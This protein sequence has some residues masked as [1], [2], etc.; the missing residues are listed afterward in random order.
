MEYKITQFGNGI[1]CALL[2][3]LIAWRLA[4][5]TGQPVVGLIK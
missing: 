4:G 5:A 3:K 2:R 1:D